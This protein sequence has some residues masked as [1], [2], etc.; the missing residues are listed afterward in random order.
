[1]KV[2]LRFSLEKMRVGSIV[3]GVALAALAMGASGTEQATATKKYP[4]YPDVWGYELPWPAKNNRQSAIMIFKKDDGDYVAMY[5]ERIHNKRRKDGS[6]CEQ[7]YQFSGISFFSREKWDGDEVGRFAENHRQD[8]VPQRFSQPNPWILKDGTELRQGGVSQG[9]CPNKL[10]WYLM[11]LDKEKNILAEKRLIYLLER[12]IKMPVAYPC[13]RNELLV[14]K[15]DQVTMRVQGVEPYI[16]PLDDGTFLLY[17]QG[18][19]IL[20]RFDRNFTTKSE[21]LNRNVFVV[22]R[23]DMDVFVA[24]YLKERNLDYNDQT[25]NDGAYDY[26]AHIKM[27]GEK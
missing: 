8:R 18:G 9:P 24:Q 13:E 5:I 25:A 26:V 10:A 22:D 20:V 7:K 14:S 16:I 19:N 1:M 2:W 11:M 12:S 23:Q 21:L 27:R 3:V 17:D 15:Q 4:P 6:C